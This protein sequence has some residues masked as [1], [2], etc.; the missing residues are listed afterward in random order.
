MTRLWAIL[1]SLGVFASSRQLPPSATLVALYYLVSGVICLALA[2]GE[3][4]F[5]PWAMAAT[6]GVGQLLTAVVLYFGLER[7]DGRR[8]AR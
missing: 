4:A 2:R 1:F 5:S 6:F 7:A 8:E 3:H